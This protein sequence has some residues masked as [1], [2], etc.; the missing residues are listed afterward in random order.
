MLLWLDWQTTIERLSYADSKVTSETL[1]E[2]NGH[3]RFCDF[4]FRQQPD[5]V[6]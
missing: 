5:E 3:Q 1:R 6:L 4:S 2:T